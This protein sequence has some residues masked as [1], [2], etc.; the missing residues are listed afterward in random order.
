MRFSIITPSFR[1]SEWLKL[2][3]AS[4]ADQDVELEHIVQDSESDDGTLE[5]LPRDK[6]VK[7][8]IE[9]DKGMYDAINRGI[10]RS[11]G[12]ILAYLNCDEQYLPGA[13]A[14]VKEFFQKNP[15]VD[16][17]FGD[18]VVV[19][20]KSEYLF[21]RKVLTPLETSTR[22]HA[23]ATLSCATFF[24]RRVITKYRAYFNPGLK[25]V[26]DAQW[27]LDLLCQNVPMAVL[28]RFTSAFA[29]SGE[30]MSTGP[31]A[32]RERK[33]LRESAPDWMRRLRWLAVL[34]HRVRNLSAG[35]YFQRPFSYSVY[36]MQNMEERTLFRVF[37]PKFRW[38]LG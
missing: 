12:D 29:A 28:R 32:Q 14:N 8:F 4:V 21:H 1:G 31:N 35:I 25:D 16:V 23:L 11:T 18:V 37:R 20:A 13:L 19:N 5:W 17:L 30:N 38:K 3:V 26:G 22:I 10:R 24:R 9:K 6:R 33:A 7:A 2:C 15:E 27:I 36:T 34:H